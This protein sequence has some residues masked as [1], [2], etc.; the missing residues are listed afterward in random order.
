[1]TAE[2]GIR[3]KWAEYVDVTHEPHDLPLNVTVTLPRNWAVMGDLESI[4]VSV[5]L[6]DPVAL[7][8][9][10]C[11]AQFMAITGKKIDEARDRYAFKVTRVRNKC[12]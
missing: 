1:M 5:K 8:L 3:I 11:F 12:K 4:N 9:E 7:L 6:T 10:L 2:D